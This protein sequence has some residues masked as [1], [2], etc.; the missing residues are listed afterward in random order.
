M[1]ENIVKCCICG[2]SIPEWWGNNPEPLVCGS[3]NG[4]LNHCCSDC[5]QM[6]IV[7]RCLLSKATEGMT[8][9]QSEA[10]YDNFSKLPLSLKIATVKGALGGKINE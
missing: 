5:D 1:K 3:E 6:V 9:E 10:V 2:K 4:V 8:D 7:A